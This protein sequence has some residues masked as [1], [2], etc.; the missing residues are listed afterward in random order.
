M[1]THLI[2]K[3]Y[4]LAVHTAAGSSIWDFDVTKGVVAGLCVD[5]H[6]CGKRKGCTSRLVSVAHAIEDMGDGPIAVKCHEDRQSCQTHV[7]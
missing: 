4:I 6:L 3:Q 7:T 1:D 5:S 2:C